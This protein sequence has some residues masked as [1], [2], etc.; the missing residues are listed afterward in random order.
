MS[1]Q[2]R[3]SG[4]QQL[5]LLGG[6]GCGVGAHSPCVGLAAGPGGGGV[7]K[8]A[9]LTGHT[10]SVRHPDFIWQEKSKASR[11]EWARGVSPGCEC[12]LLPLDGPSLPTSSP[13]STFPDLPRA[14]RSLLRPCLCPGSLSLQTPT[15]GLSQGGRG[16]LHTKENYLGGSPT[17]WTKHCI[18]APIQDHR[19]PASSPPS[20]AVTSDLSARLRCPAGSR[21][22]ARS[23][24]TPCPSA[25]RTFPAGSGTGFSA[26]WCKAR[27]PRSPALVGR[28]ESSAEGPH[29]GRRPPPAHRHSLWSQ[30][31]HSWQMER[32]FQCSL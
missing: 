21:R 3:A 15:V 11:G 7:L 20:S 9:C 32:W 24:Y 18:P 30:G 2:V 31:R 8:V 4:G 13:H 26:C 10:V 27:S 29:S 14:D 23:V 1:S 25:R 28:Q 16:A 22:V 19:H 12:P 5:G 17:P 6:Q